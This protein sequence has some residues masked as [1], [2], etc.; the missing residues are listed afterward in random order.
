MR[1]GNGSTNKSKK[2]KFQ[3]YVSVFENN[4]FQIVQNLYASKQLRTV[5]P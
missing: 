4:Q 1:L 5:V 3:I 2:G